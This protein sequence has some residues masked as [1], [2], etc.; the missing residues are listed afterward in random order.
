MVTGIVGQLRNEGLFSGGGGSSLGSPS[1]GPGDTA[2]QR[3]PTLFGGAPSTVSVPP[4]LPSQ[5]PIP[6]LQPNAGG[7]NSQL[8]AFMAAIRQRESNGNYQAIGPP[9]RFGTAKGAYQFIDSTWGGFGGFSRADHAPPHVQ[10]QRAAQLMTQYYNTYGSWELV[11]IAWH[12]GPGTAD[13]IMRGGSLQGISDGYTATSQYAQDVM[14]I[15]AGNM[16]QGGFGSTTSNAAPSGFHVD[17]D[18]ALNNMIAAAPGRITVTSGVRTYEEQKVLY[19]CFVNPS[20]GGNLAANPDEGIGSLHQHGFAADLG[21]DSPATR[22]WAHAN[23]SRFGLEFNLLDEGEWWHVRLIGAVDRVLAGDSVTAG[24]SGPGVGPGA[25]GIIGPGPA[26]DEEIEQYVNANFGPLAAYLDHPELGPILRE[27]GAQRVDPAI[28]EGRIRNT[29]W[30][31]TT[32]LSIRDFDARE[33]QDP[34]TIRD[35]IENRS[36]EI[37]NLASTLGLD[38]DPTQLLELSRNSLRLGWTDAELSRAIAARVEALDVRQ[39]VTRGGMG[40]MARDIQQ[41][42]QQYMVNVDD[43]TVASYVARLISGEMSMDTI[44]SELVIRSMER[45]PHLAERVQNGTLPADIFA[46]HRQLIASLTGQ[47]AENIDLINDETWF[48]VLSSSDEAGN[49]RPMTID[50]TYR[51]TRGTDQFGNSRLGQQQSAE[52]TRGLLE[53]FGAIA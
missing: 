4:Y 49:I 1:P 29:A 35:E 5:N 15:M 6:N 37:N 38:L 24:V 32:Q 27:A 46:E 50:E 20:C 10:D 21:F 23:A 41:V 11:A 2:Q 33:L 22:A 44:R 51:F 28:L 34:A 25:T 19:D 14:A 18:R 7:F 36:L 39:V 45:F 53:T 9:T 42:A 31:Q 26:S 17:M 3:F 12:A 13:S 40:E 47:S 48:P 43:Q 30:W 52:L 16:G 8:A